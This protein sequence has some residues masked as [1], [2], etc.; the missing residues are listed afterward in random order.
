MEMFMELSVSAQEQ[1]MTDIESVAEAAR[2]MGTDAHVALIVPGNKSWWDG[3]IILMSE[4]GSLHLHIVYDNVQLEMLERYYSRQLCAQNKYAFERLRQASKLVAR[5]RH[6]P[7]DVC[8]RGIKNL[9]AA[10]TVSTN[11]QNT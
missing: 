7:I 4:S 8:D 5:S 3:L 6:P 10:L 1:V 2:N 9:L 11:G